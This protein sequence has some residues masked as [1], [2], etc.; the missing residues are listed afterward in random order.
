MLLR[1]AIGAELRAA[2]ERQGFTQ[3][4]LAVRSGVHRTHISLI[5]R[6][7]RTPTLTVL[8][9]VCDAM[10]VDPADLV[11]RVRRRTSREGGGQ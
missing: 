11:R 9:L 3:E 5:E 6:G 2:R 1:E 8:F 10:G 7:Q 4:S